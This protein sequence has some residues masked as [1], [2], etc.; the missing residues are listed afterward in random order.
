MI[1]ASSGGGRGLGNVSDQPG[2]KRGLLK[3]GDWP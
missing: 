1:G 2:V 3:E